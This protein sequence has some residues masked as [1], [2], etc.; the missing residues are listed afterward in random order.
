MRPHI[1]PPTA[2]FL[3]YS[4]WMKYDIKKN[5]TLIDV[6]IIGKIEYRNV[7]FVNP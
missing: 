1:S 3:A 6:T 7:T 2:K 5:A 4:K